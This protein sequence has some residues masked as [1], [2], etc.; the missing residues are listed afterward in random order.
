MDNNKEIDNI[1]LRSGKVRHIIGK[2]PPR[3][4]RT[5]T[6]IIT[7]VV[8]ALGIAFYTIH[9]PVTIESRGKVFTQDSVRIYVPY[10]YLYIFN[11]PR[12][13]MITYEGQNDDA[14]PSVYQI[15]QHNDSLITHKGTNYFT[16]TAFVGSGSSKVKIGQNINARIVVCD[17]TL[18][19]QIFRK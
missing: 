9:Y 10:K 19:Q 13:T 2:V 5:G 15:A 8:I 1:E 11:E 7:L 3:L 6:V 18:W 4:V 16:A 17:K 14:S 12:Q